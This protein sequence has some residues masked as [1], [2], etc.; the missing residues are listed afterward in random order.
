MKTGLVADEAQFAYLK[1][2]KHPKTIPFLEKENKKE[3][4]F[5]KRHGLAKKLMKEFRARQGEE[6][7][8]LAW[9][10]SDGI[11]Y[12]FVYREGQELETLYRNGKPV[13]D[14]NELD[15]VNPGSIVPFGNSCIV[16]QSDGEPFL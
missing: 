1:D 8:E 16:G 3:D 13:L 14:L 11:T 9:T 5:M 12:Q 15:I 6:E 10:G 2:L 4:R 7:E